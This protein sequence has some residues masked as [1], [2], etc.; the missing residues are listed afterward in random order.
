MVTVAN[1]ATQ[2]HNEDGWTTTDASL[3]N[4]EYL[5]DKAI[6]F[7]NLETGTTIADLS[8]AADSKSLT[9]TEGE[10]VAVKLLSSLLIRARRDKGPNA[11]FSSLS[12]TQVIQDPHYSLESELFKMSLERLRGRTILRT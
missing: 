12:I 8:G 11:S 10:I 9:G 6:D 1:I 3:T 2:I 5:I 4:T 7:I